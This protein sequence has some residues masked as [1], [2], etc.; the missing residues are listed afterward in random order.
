M[1]ANVIVR[2]YSLSS[3]SIVLPA[4]NS[5]HRLRHRLQKIA[6]SELEAYRVLSQRQ[7]YFLSILYAFDHLVYHVVRKSETVDICNGRGMF[8]SVVSAVE[9]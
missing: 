1:L 5:H 2:L 6:N 8:G 7:L 9:G 3:P 4:D